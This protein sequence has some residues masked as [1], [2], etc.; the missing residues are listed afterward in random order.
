VS[1]VLGMGLSVTIH[2]DAKTLIESSLLSVNHRMRPVLHLEGNRGHV[3]VF[4][5]RPELMRL[6]DAVDSVLT[7]LDLVEA[8]ERESAA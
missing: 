3:S 6:R 5:G 4:A 7:D 2:L 1:A 8:Q